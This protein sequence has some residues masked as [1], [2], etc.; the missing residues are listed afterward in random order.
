MDEAN[1]DEDGGTAFYLYSLSRHEAYGGRRAVEF[2]A[3]EE[4]VVIVSRVNL[5]YLNLS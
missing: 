5:I 3:N 1:D 4:F 2:E